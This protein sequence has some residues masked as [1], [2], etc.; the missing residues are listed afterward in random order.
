MEVVHGDGSSSP[1]SDWQA[2]MHGM[3]NQVVLYNPTNKAL[4]ITGAASHH[5]STSQLAWDDEYDTVDDNGHDDQCPY[6]H[7]PMTQNDAS[8][9]YPR[10]PNY[11][12]L[13]AEST[14]TSR[15]QTPPSQEPSSNGRPFGTDAMAEGYFDT[16]FR[17]EKKLGMGANGS[18]FLCQHVLDGNLL[19]HFAVKKIAVGSSH[20]YLVQILR[21]VLERFDK[22][23]RKFSVDLIVSMLWYCIGSVIGNSASPKHNHIP[24]CLARIMPFLFIWPIGTH[25]SCTNAMG[26]RW[27]VL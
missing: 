18:V 7:R 4:T 11:F 2:I 26:R 5:E 21:E 17:E 24:P 3:N 13:L 14:T 6:C 27:K 9:V 12:H 10:V 16:F 8:P 1:A 19:G 22:M 20:E 15:A 25:S 23:F